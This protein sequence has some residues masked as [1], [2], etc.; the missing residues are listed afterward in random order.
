MYQSQIYVSFTF[1]IFFFQYTLVIHF[2]TFWKGRSWHDLYSINHLIPEHTSIVVSSWKKTYI[3]SDPFLL[4]LAV[5]L[6]RTRLGSKEKDVHNQTHIALAS[7]TSKQ[8][9][10]D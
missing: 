10:G 2:K 3:I 1:E 8:K 5:K 4:C 9:A 6:Y 7:V